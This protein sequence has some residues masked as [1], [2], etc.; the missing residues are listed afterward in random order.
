MHG[1]KV[2]ACHIRYYIG[3]AWGIRALIKKL[4]IESVSKLRDEFIN[5]SLANVYCS[6]CQIME[7]LGLKDLSRKLVAICVISYFLAYLPAEDPRNLKL[8][9]LCAVIGTKMLGIGRP[10][11]PAPPGASTPPPLCASPHARMR[12]CNKLPIYYGNSLLRGFV[13][14][15]VPPTMF[16][17]VYS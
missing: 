14:I 8:M 2:L 3:I 16:Q 1:Y 15:F 17:Q 13:S 6:T 11:L 9:A 7:Q 5:P 10:P 12:R 4:I